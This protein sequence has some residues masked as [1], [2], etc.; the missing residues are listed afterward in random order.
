MILG[1]ARFAA[2]CPY[3]SALAALYID[4]EDPRLVF[5]GVGASRTIVALPLMYTNTLSSSSRS[6]GKVT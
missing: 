4:E 2:A 5:G 6:S 1:V 3:A